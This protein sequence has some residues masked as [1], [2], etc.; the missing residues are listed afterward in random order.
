MPTS[1]KSSEPFDTSISLKSI[2]RYYPRSPGRSRASAAYEVNVTDYV[3]S[4]VS[5]NFPAVY[6]YNDSHLSFMINE[7]QL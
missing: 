6:I 5:R 3:V 1:Q 7:F 2:E 4:N